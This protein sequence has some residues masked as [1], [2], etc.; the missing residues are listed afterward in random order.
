M[1]NP[2]TLLGPGGRREVPAAHSDFT[3]S[4]AFSLDGR[5]LATASNDNTAVIR[6][7]ETC[8]PAAPPLRFGDGCNTVVFHPRAGALATGSFDR[9]PRLV[10]CDP[11]LPQLSE[12]RPGGMVGSA[13]FSPD[14]RWLLVGTWEPFR[15][16][17]LVLFRVDVVPR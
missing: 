1:P 4:L 15:P 5:W 9:S 11:T 12:I 13:A 14:G 2:L 17:N 6:D 7:G 10:R 8:Q 16:G 3:R